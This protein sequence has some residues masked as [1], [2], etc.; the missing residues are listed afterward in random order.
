MKK[1]EYCGK[2]H[3]GSYGSGRFCNHTCASKFSNAFVSE[4]GRANQIK[5]LTNNDNINKSIQARK[6]KIANEYKKP[7]KVYRNDLRPVFSNSL[8]LGKIGE[9]EV[10]KTFLQ[11]GYKVYLPLVDDG[12]GIDM[13]IKA[14]NDDYKTVQVKS[15]ASSMINENGECESSSYRIHKIHRNIHD[16]TYTQTRSK[17]PTEVV[18]YFALYSAYEDEAYL[19]KNTD[20]LSYEVTIRNTPPANNQDKCV[21]YANDYQIDKVLYK[22]NPIPGVYYEDENVIDCDFEEIN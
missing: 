22:M 11:H 9:L 18:N 13:V 16:G 20:D 19:L 3:D 10:A 1:C 12:D 21:H 15:T 5:A 8:Q 17:Y 6:N 4:A 2:T 7:K 14:D